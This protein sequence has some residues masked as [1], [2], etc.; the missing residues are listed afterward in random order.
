[1]AF[2]LRTYDVFLFAG[3]VSTGTKSGW[4]QL[5]RCLDAF[6]QAPIKTEVTTNQK[7]GRLDW[8]SWSKWAGPRF[9]YAFVS[10]PSW[11]ESVRRSRSPDAVFQT[12]LQSPSVR[13]TGVVSL[14]MFACAIDSPLHA[15]AS[16]AATEL[17]RALRATCLTARKPWGRNVAGGHE[18][19][20][21][22]FI[23]SIEP[24]E[25][26]GALRLPKWSAFG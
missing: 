24:D 17:A 1:M 22:Y 14:S 7:L 2:V 10:S 15:L 19:F 26:T 11:R 13:R 5:A 23:F 8:K 20:L 4:R 3:K 9:D 18:A 25:R 21:Q 16:G 12:Q 6:F